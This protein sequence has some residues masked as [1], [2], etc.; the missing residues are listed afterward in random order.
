[1][2]KGQKR[3]L[4]ILAILED[5]FEDLADAGGLMSF[6]YRQVYG[7]VPAKYKKHNFEMAVRNALKIGNIERVIKNGEVYIRLT[8]RGKNKLVQQIPLLRFQKKKWDRKWRIIFFDIEEKNRNLR[9]LFREK[10]RELGFGRLQ[11]SVYISPFP[12][13]EEMREFIEAIGLK[14]KVYL[15]VSPN[16]PVSDE[17]SLARR[18]WRLD[19]INNEYRKILERLQKRELSQKEAR[20]IRSLYLEVLATDP[21]LPVELLSKDWLREKVEKEIRKLKS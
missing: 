19:Q 16:L 12:I 2:I 10:L 9:D 6:S 1:M 14:E 3:L 20:E 18:V 15:L 5:L 7:Y 8:A 11:K 21:F 4:I 13:E 17:K